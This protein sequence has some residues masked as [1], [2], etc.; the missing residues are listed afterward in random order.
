MPP[1]LSL[2]IILLAQAVGSLGM[3]GAIWVIQAAH[4]PLQRHVEEQQFVTF[5][6]SH[7]RR[8]SYVVGPL[9]LVEAGTAAWLLFIPMCGCGLTLSWVGMGLVFLVWISTIVLQVPCHWKLERGRDDAAIRRLVATNWV[10][11]LGWTARAVVVG[12]LLVL[13]M[14]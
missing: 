11:T 14:G 2:D 1:E 5:Q 12:W 4:Y 3:F 6:A 9:M 10:R 13:Q 8:I 7:M